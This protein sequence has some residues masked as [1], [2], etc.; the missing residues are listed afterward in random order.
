VAEEIEQRLDA[1]FGLI[2]LDPMRRVFEIN[3]L[4]VFTQTQAGLG[5]RAYAEGVTLAPKSATRASRAAIPR[6]LAAPYA[7]GRDTN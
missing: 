6:W 1:T 3:R 7:I 2:V 5:E 4:A